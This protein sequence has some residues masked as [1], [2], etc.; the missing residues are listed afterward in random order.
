MAMCRRY[1]NPATL[2]SACIA[3]IDADDSG[4]NPALFPAPSISLATFERVIGPPRSVVK[5]KA[6]SGWAGTVASSLFPPILKGAHR[7]AFFL[8]ILAGSLTI[9]PFGDGGTVK[10]WAAYWSSF[11]FSNCRW[12]PSVLQT[13]ARLP[14]H[15]FS[16]ARIRSRSRQWY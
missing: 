11:L 16:V 1:G 2:I 3:A 7:A 15:W 9:H 6:D 13:L 4:G 12:M 14:P 10:P 8:A 5:T